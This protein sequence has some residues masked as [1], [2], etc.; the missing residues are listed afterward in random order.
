MNTQFDNTDREEKEKEVDLAFYKV[1]K[2]FFLILVAT[3]ISAFIT[4]KVVSFNYVPSSSMENTL[5]VR[6]ITIANRMYKEI[7]RNDIILFVLSE[8][9]RE[10]IH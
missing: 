10:G 9:L 4:R 1:F 2:F 6:D 3:F 8:E 5:L 7:N